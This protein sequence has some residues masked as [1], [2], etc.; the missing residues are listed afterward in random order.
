MR[1]ALGSG[2]GTTPTKPEPAGYHSWLAAEAQNARGERR[3]AFIETGE[4]YAVTADAA[5]TN[6][7]AL[8]AQKLAGAFTPSTAF[9]AAHVL[10]VSGVRLIDIEPET[11]SLPLRVHKGTCRHS[12]RR[13]AKFP[14]TQAAL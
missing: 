12:S 4:G 7:E 6:V 5:V 2:S 3:T 10:K 9:G 13:A 11:V 14:E 8:L 1:R